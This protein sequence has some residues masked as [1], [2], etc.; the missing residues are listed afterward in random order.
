MSS[1]NKNA[2]RGSLLLLPYPESVKTA[3]KVFFI[4]AGAVCEYAGF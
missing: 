4:G 2:T 3:Q 1:R